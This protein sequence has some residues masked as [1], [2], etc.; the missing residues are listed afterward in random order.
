MTAVR[1]PAGA[2]LLTGDALAAVRY[3]VTVAQRAR[4]RNGLP[5]SVA[6]ARLAAVV[7]PAGHADAPDEP[8][9]ESDY[10]TTDEAAALLGFSARQI[11]RLAPGLGGHIIGGR[12]LLDRRAV[13][14]HIQ[15]RTT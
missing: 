9:G 10:V 15:G 1:L 13:T 12:W 7:S 14:E 4:A 6:L 8:A 2:V 3:A 5:P 11:R